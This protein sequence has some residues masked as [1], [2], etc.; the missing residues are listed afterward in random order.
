MG[1][2]IEQCK[3][4]LMRR[5]RNDTNSIREVVL[6]VAERQNVVLSDKQIDHAVIYLKYGKVIW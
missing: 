3:T 4:I 6:Q 5:L 2:I 1:K